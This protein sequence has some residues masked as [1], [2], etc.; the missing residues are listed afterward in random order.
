MIPCAGSGDTSSG[1]GA[2]L[3][4]NVLVSRSARASRQISSSPPTAGRTCWSWLRRKRRGWRRRREYPRDRMLALQRRAQAASAAAPVDSG[5]SEN[6]RFRYAVSG[7]IRRGSRCAPST[8][9]RRSISSSRRHRARRAAAAV[10][11]RAGRRRANWSTTVSARRI[12]SWIGCSA[13]P[14]FAGGDKGDVVRIERT[15]GVARRMTMSGTT[16]RPCHAAGGR[17]R[18]TVALRAQPPGH[19]PEPAHAGHPCR[20]PVGRRARGH[21]LVA[22]TAAARHQRAD[23]ALQRRS[24][25]EVRRAG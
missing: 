11:D 7:V 19:A 10:R 6:L 12:T 24:R 14:N 3:R 21:D 9:V 13:R 23:R 2:D 8:T 15:D 4:V 1:S 5:L 17:S 18:R 22:A 20:R 25:L 16:P